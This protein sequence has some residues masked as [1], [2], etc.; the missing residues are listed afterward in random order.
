MAKTASLVLL[1]TKTR[2]IIHQQHERAPE[3]PLYESDFPSGEGGWVMP[4]LFCVPSGFLRVFYAAISSQHPSI[5]A[6]I[7]RP[8]VP[9]DNLIGKN[10]RPALR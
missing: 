2:V 9:S 8:A 4:S 5:A 6:D 10:A 7:L 3:R 1:N